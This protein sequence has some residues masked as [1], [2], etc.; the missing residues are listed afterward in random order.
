MNEVMRAHNN[1]QQ[2]SLDAYYELEPRQIG[3]RQLHVLKII[4]ALG[5]CTDKMVSE[6]SSIPINVVTARRN[7]LVK[8][9][10]VEEARKGPCTI[11]GRNAIWWRVRE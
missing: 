2:T 1:M 8:M 3:Q 4:R 6:A 11:T 10:K 7:E 9:G 5:E